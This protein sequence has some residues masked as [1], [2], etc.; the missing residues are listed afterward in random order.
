MQSIH[1]E[2]SLILQPDGELI[3][4]ILDPATATSAAPQIQFDIGVLSQK[5]P[6][7]SE[8]EQKTFDDFSQPAQLRKL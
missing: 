6:Q 4:A 5:V 8:T 1:R 2:T 7:D 3:R